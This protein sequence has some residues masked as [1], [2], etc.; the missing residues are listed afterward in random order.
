VNN[1]WTQLKQPASPPKPKRG[2]PRVV[3]PVRE[4]RYFEPGFGTLSERLKK[5][6]LE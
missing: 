1:L 2:R 5:L 4:P 3:K 6:G